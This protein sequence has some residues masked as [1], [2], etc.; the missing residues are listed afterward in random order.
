[1]DKCKKAWK[2]W[3]KGY[4]DKPNGKQEAKNEKREFYCVNGT[5]KLRPSDDADV[6]YTDAQIE[7]MKNKKK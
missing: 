3:E 5:I 1:M 7:S 4:A 2:K 6:P